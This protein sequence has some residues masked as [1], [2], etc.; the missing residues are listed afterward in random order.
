MKRHAVLRA[1][2]VILTSDDVRPSSE[3]VIG[4]DGLIEEVRPAAELTEAEAASCLAPG[5]I[6]AHTHLDLGALRGQVPA[7]G[8]FVAWVGALMARRGALSPEELA[9]GALRSADAVLRSGTTFA[10]DIDGGHVPADVLAD[11]PLRRLRLRELIDGAPGAAD[12]RT[13]EALSVARA[14]LTA[15]SGAPGANRVIEGWS[16]H[17]PHTVGDALLEGLAALAP[18]EARPPMAIHWA[19]SDE[20]VQWLRDGTGPFAPFLGPSPRTSG[21]RRLGDRGLLGGAMLV[22][23]NIPDAG[24]LERIRAASPPAAIVHC[25]GSHLFFGRDAFGGAAGL[26]M[27]IPLLLGT[28][29]WASNDELDMG[30]EVRMARRTLGLDARGAFECAT[31]APARF[32]PD[33]AITGA[34]TPGSAADVVRYGPPIAPA[35]PRWSA[36][37]AVETLTTHPSPV[38]SV[39]VGGVMVGP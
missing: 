33:P 31:T 15:A 10:F 38:L 19:E 27:G 9:Q 28:D 22:H 20:E 2:T 3:V 1:G 34:L 21:A 12:E 5:W 24:D 16:P 4:A 6:N 37:D 26:A 35:G 36:R 13:E 18:P 14:A 30:R 8:G 29:S 32:V 17:A 11:H 39:T 23:G 7:E 25:P